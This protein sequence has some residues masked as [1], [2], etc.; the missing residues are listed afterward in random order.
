MKTLGLQLAALHG[1][2]STWFVAAAT[3]IVRF[4]SSAVLLAFSGLA[5]PTAKEWQQALLMGLF[6]GT[7]ML[8]QM[9]AHASIPQASS[10]STSAFHS[11]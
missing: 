4:G 3:L 2:I 6:T 11:P 5:R 1:G 7:G 10:A 9:D 8:F